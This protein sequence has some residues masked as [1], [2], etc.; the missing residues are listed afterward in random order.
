[1]KAFR[2]HGCRHTSSFA[3]PVVAPAA[4]PEKEEVVAVAAAV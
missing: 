3:K 2:E 1:M 4:K